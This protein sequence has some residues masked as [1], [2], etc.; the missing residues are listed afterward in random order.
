MLTCTMMVTTTSCLQCS[1]NPSSLQLPVPI[2]VLQKVSQEVVTTTLGAAPVPGAYCQNRNQMEFF[3]AWKAALLVLLVSVLVNV[4]YHRVVLDVKVQVDWDACWAASHDELKLCRQS[5]SVK[6]TIEAVPIHVEQGQLE[7]LQRKLRDRIKPMWSMVGIQAR[8]KESWSD[9][10]DVDYLEG[11]LQFWEQDYKW[12]EAENELNGMHPHQA[13]IDGLKVRYLHVKTQTSHST[14]SL[15]K[16]ASTRIT[17]ANTSVP[18]LLL[19][20]W[21]GSVYE[22]HKLI[23]DLQTRDTN[24]EFVVPFLPG[25]G[26]S[27]GAQRP[28]L[29]VCAI[30][31]IMSKLMRALG[32]PS[33]IVQGGDWGSFIA[34]CLQDI[35]PPGEVIGMHINMPIVSLP[36]WTPLYAYLFETDS[37]EIAKAD[38]LAIPKKL[39]E[40]TPY[41][42][43]QA[44][45]PKTLGVGLEDSPVALAAWV[46]D[47]FKLW[48]DAKSNITNQQ[49][50]T[51]LMLYWLP[52]AQ[53]SS[54]M[55]YR[56]S[57]G[58]APANLFTVLFQK[59]VHCK[60]G[61]SQFPYEIMPPPAFT[62]ST[63][64]KNI[65]TYHKAT[66]GGH[67]A[68]LEQPHA[69]AEHIHEFV[70]A[71]L[72]PQG[73][74][75]DIL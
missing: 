65:V 41:L 68:A 73:T 15:Q 7:L 11:V 69:L 13:L 60:T 10:I 5:P 52:Q 3:R 39:F 17:K 6:D 18:L 30:A 51:N 24:Y 27:Q 72:Y 55:L 28:G 33:Y 49:L 22:F 16:G 35:T 75:N 57:F 20:G 29:N 8:S 21:P 61:I 47:K 53:T 9:G 56:E 42:L 12:R 58:R 43:Q 54:A 50:V 1:S 38:I 31:V 19:H 4:Y 71:L 74:N 40:T 64:Y 23:A 25:Y 46:L 36:L 34:H 59:P 14:I 2:G 67:F 45:R 44:T 70:Q 62:L 37:A 48:T 66:R 26:F 32:K 63:R